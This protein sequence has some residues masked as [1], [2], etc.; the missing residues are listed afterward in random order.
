MHYAFP[1]NKSHIKWNFGW[2]RIFHLFVEHSVV[3]Q[4][5]HCIWQYV[6]LPC[7]S[8]LIYIIVCL[9]KQQQTSEHV[10]VGTLVALTTTSHFYTNTVCKSY[11]VKLSVIQ[12]SYDC[13]TLN[14]INVGNALKNSWN[15]LRSVVMPVHTN[16]YSY[17]F[18]MYICMR[19]WT[20]FGVVNITKCI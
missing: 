20:T 16:Q 12:Q 7:L 15:V 1:Y 3:E 14:T 2:T 10:E 8:L 6:I 13:L 18:D 17:K 4:R 11:Y 9:Y 5:F 19:T